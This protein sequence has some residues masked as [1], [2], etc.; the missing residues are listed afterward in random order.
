MK[1]LEAP[2]RIV[3]LFGTGLVG[4]A[5]LAALRQER[6]FD[7]RDFPLRWDLLASE[8]L[9]AVERGISEALAAA[10]GT[11]CQVVWAAG[12]TG[13]SAS[14]A[15]IDAELASFRSVTGSI[16][17]VLSAEC[18][19]P[20][21]FV[22]LSSAGG[23]FEGQ[24]VVR[25]ESAP[26]PRSP[27]ARLK[28]RQEGIA[29]APGVPWNPRILRAS[30]VY[31]PIRPGHRL[32]LVPT[33]IANGLRQQ[34]TRITARMDT[35]RDFVWVGDVARH[36]VRLVLDD[37]AAAASEP[38]ILASARPVSLA[39]VQELVSSILGRRIYVSYAARDNDVD[40]T[41]HP[42]AVA[43]GFVASELR[44]NATRVYHDAL[45]RG[46]RLAARAA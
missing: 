33:L 39:E 45:E 4:S 36:V 22:L 13:F 8:E 12:A 31:G 20:A 21:G 28:A 37:T 10:R 7:E 44:G 19:A 27:Y 6:P 25:R 40:I 5:V 35:L 9:A 15:E 32:G 2:D 42:D 41:F 38:Q 23:L 3:A 24:R 17:R 11:P 43:P 26:S 30:S 18:D 16:A 34:P 29:N 14:E 1:L 46:V